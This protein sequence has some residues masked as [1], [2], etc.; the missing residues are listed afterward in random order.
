MKLDRWRAGMSC[1]AWCL[2]SLS[3]ISGRNPSS[4]LPEAQHFNT[5]EKATEEEI[6]NRLLGR[7][8]K[9]LFISL[10]KKEAGEFY[11]A[12][13]E[14]ERVSVYPITHRRSLVKWANTVKEHRALDAE[15]AIIQ[16]RSLCRGMVPQELLVQDS[17]P[18]RSD[19]DS[20][21]STIAQQD[22]VG[23]TLER[24]KPSGPTGSIDKPRGS[25]GTTLDTTQASAAQSMCDSDAHKYQ[26]PEPLPEQHDEHPP[27][28][29]DL[30]RVASSVPNPV[31]VRRPDNYSGSP[32]GRAA[33]VRSCLVHPV[34]LSATSAALGGFLAWVVLAYEPF[35]E[36]VVLP[37]SLK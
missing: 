33:R 21:V 9:L 36:L 2:R 22:D 24:L 17:L 26:Q 30:L 25:V 7:G 4:H 3:V 28:K 6:I 5:S 18:E 12:V 1:C 14:K 11:D 35:G 20:G 16:K 37:V 31:D 15:V 23:G 13:P 32:A 19:S 10:L 34:V 29:H 27:A 8:P